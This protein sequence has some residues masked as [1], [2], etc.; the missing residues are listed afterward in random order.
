[1]LF[2]KYSKCYTIIVI[3]EN[4]SV[5]D[6]TLKLDMKEKKY[7]LHKLHANPNAKR[8]MYHSIILNFH[9]CQYA[10]II[11]EVK[12]GQHSIFYSICKITS[13]KTALTEK[14]SHSNNT[15]IITPI[16]ENKVTHNSFDFTGLTIWSFKSSITFTRKP[17]NFILTISMLIAR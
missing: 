12:L 11:L 4:R 2:S 17:I 3:S 6:E 13:L 10:D 1:M 8:N 5:V 15:C 9:I 7:F 16:I 14:S